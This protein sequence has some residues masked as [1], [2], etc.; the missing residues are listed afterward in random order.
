M[1]TRLRRGKVVEIPEKWLHNITTRTTIRERNDARIEVR[2]ARKRR[3]RADRK[4]DL[5][6]QLTH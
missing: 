1:A 5:E 2:T 6:N 4:F 3:L